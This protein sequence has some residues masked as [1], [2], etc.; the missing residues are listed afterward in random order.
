MAGPLPTAH[1]VALAGGGYSDHSCPEPRGSPARSCPSDVPR[2]LLPV[3][4]GQ[5]VSPMNFG[6]QGCHGLAILGKRVVKRGG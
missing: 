1:S 6:S 4:G 3:S 2:S 5:Q